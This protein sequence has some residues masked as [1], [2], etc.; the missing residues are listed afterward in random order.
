[1][2]RLDSVLALSKLLICA[3]N[4]A[5]LT[6]P[7]LFKVD[8]SPRILSAGKERFGIEL[9]KPAGNTSFGWVYYLCSKSAIIFSSNSI[10]LPL[11]EDLILM[12]FPLYSTTTNQRYL[13][14]IANT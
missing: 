7:Y 14:F 3:M 8:T 1:M 10:T 13:N 9:K 2:R 6:T 12:P 11:S 4:W 5:L